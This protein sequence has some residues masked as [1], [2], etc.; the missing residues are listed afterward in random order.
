[1]LEI[2]AAWEER[3]RRVNS[4]RYCFLFSIEAVEPIS[5]IKGHIKGAKGNVIISADHDGAVE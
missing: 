3:T 4:G 5:R 1:M 2:G